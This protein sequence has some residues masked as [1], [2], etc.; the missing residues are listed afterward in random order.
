MDTALTDYEH[1]E[2]PAG[3]RKGWLP[4]AT[5]WIGVGIDLSG[6]I[7]GVELVHGMGFWP[8]VA[9]TLTGSLLL[10]LLAMACA[11]AGAATG[12]STAMISRRVFGRAGGSIIALMIAV[13]SLGWFGVQTGFFATNA[14]IAIEQLFGWSAPLWLLSVIGG[15]LMMLTAFWGYRAIQRL[16]SWAVPLLVVLLGVAIVMALGRNGTSALGAA[17]EATLSFGGAVSLTTGVFVLGA[18]LAPDMARWAR[19]R[20]DAMIAGFIGFFIGNSFIII[21]AAFFAQVMGLEDLMSALF[22]LGLGVVAFLVLTLA[23]WT[24]NTTNLYSG[25]L[26]LSAVFQSIP[27][28]ALTVIA[29]S[30]AIGAAIAGIYDVFIPF[31]SAMSSVVAPFAGVYLA[32][33]LLDPTDREHEVP[34]RTARLLPLACWLLGCLVSFLTTRPTDGLGLGAFTLTTIPAL[35][36]LLTAFALQALSGLVTRR[37]SHA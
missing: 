29:G 3:E 5:I 26:S 14:Q 30:A 1:G 16:S 31:I 11:Y 17:T 2:V 22:A 37:N 23:Q 32:D 34:E 28:P 25:S 18:V 24:T 20:R 15:A 13:S 9:A 4:I 12:M 27:R 8:A 19:T 35:D 6:T 10:G 7:L 21:V 33:L 36:G